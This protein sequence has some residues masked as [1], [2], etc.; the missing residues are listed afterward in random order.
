QPNPTMKSN[1]DTTVIDLEAMP[2]D[3]IPATAYKPQRDVK[4]NYNAD[5]GTWEID[6]EQVRVANNYRLAWRKMADTT[7]FRTLYPAIIPPG[8]T[9]IHGISSTVFYKSPSGVGIGAFASSFLVDFLLRA[10]GMA[11]I[12][13]STF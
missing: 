1:L 6:G 4:P 13:G 8:A 10:T 3:F 5:Y 9:H 7:G 12:L 11:N 2:E